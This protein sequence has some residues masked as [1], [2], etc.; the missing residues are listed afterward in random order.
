M[1]VLR[2]DFCMESGRIFFLVEILCYRASIEP[3]NIILRSSFYTQHVSH[4]KHYPT[5]I[6][7]YILAS[8]FV[9][10]V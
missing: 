2:K 8:K 4:W 3:V 7:E 6:K 1:D 9:N 10:D 5:V